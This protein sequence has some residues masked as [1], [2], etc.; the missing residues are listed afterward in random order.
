MLSVGATPDNKSYCTEEKWSE[1]YD[2]S[3]LHRTRHCWS[4]HEIILGVGY[5][6]S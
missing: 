3:E 2:V 5:F 4:I 1:M 6:V